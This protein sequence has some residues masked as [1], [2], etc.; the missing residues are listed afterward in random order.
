MSSMGNIA[1]AK[2]TYFRAGEF[3]LCKF[4]H[5][6][7]NHGDTCGVCGATYGESFAYWRK[8]L[9]DEEQREKEAI[10]AVDELDASSVA[11][12]QHA[13]WPKD[14]ES[15][16]VADRIS[17]CNKNVYEN[18]LK[19]IYPLEKDPE[20]K[21]HKYCGVDAVAALTAFCPL[22][23]AIKTGSKFTKTEVLKEAV[24]HKDKP[25][26]LAHLS[27]YIESGG[28]RLTI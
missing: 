19:L 13:D 5:M 9:A 10:E 14:Y 16:D 3:S 2:D 12:A 8:L 26:R 1:D 4:S 6:D 7:I 17:D 21:K 23:A 22:Y 11:G 25:L 15:I 28:N 18:F 27:L 20:W 24:K